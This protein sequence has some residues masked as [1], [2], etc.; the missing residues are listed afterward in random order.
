M[1]IIVTAFNIHTRIIKNLKSEY[2][3]LAI[4]LQKV[5]KQR[6]FIEDSDTEMILKLIPTFGLLLTY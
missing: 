2:H 5:K 6:T 4:L 1:C 3:L